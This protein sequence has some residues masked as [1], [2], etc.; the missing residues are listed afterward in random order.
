MIASPN[1][2][3]RPRYMTLSRWIKKSGYTKNAFHGKKNAGVWVEGQ[4]W[5]KSPDG[6][7]QVDWREIESWIESNYDRRE[8]EQARRR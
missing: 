5:I 2:G 6:K 3:Q 1:E 7:I 8:L 4:H